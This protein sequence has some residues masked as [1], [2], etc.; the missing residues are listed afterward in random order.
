MLASHGHTIVR[1]HGTPSS[2]LHILQKR[3][4]SSVTRP[5]PLFNCEGAMR[6][7]RGSHTNTWRDYECRVPGNL[8]LSLPQVPGFFK[9]LGPYSI[10][11]GRS[12]PLHFFLALPLLPLQLRDALQ[13]SPHVL[14]PF[15]AGADLLVDVLR[16]LEVISG[17]RQLAAL[18]VDKA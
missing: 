7:S 6:I 12:L 5:Y 10:E 9:S 11:E 15:A 2:F 14:G 8:T 3:T 17:L 13:R 1:A 18:E 16:L 4:A